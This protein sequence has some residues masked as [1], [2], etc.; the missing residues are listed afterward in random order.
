MNIEELLL[1]LPEHAKDIKINLKNVLDAERSKLSVKQIGIVALACAV[2][3]KNKNIISAIET[4]AKEVL[5]E[6][7]LNAAKGAAVIMGMN[8]IYYRFV[9]LSSN[10]TYSSMPPALRMQIIATHGIDKIDFELAS[11]AVSAINGCGACIDSHEANLKKEGLTEDKIQEAIKISAV[12]NA[13][14]F[15]L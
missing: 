9:H 1:S 15:V 2:S 8:N 4:K 12:I 13:V 6:K 10:K 14:G 5:D 11:L 3:T 7:E